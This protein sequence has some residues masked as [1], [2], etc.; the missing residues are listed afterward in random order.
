MALNENFKGFRGDE[1]AEVT[2]NF[3]NG[4]FTLKLVGYRLGSAR[5]YPLPEEQQTELCNAYFKEPQ[6]FTLGKISKVHSTSGEKWNV[7]V[8]KIIM[9]RDGTFLL[10]TTR[11]VY[12]LSKVKDEKPEAPEAKIIE[13]PRANI[14]TRLKNL[15]L[16][17]WG[18]ND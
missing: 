5:A 9:E 3:C 18:A 17:K 16:K 13:Q 8:Q 2:Q 12:R 1:V 15:L 6:T 14:L 4:T 11:S 10:F 7:N